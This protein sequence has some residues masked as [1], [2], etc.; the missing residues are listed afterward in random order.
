MVN[1]IDTKGRTALHYAS[2]R[3]YKDI[4]ILLL[5]KGAK[6]NIVDQYGYTP[7]F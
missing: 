1:A 5:A 3:G 2:D 7:Q 4:I 6:K